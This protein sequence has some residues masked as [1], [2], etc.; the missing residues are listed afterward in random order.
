MIKEVFDSEHGKY[1]LD[2]RGYP[3][4]LV[5]NIP[6]HIKVFD[7]KYGSI[8]RDGLELHHKDGNKRNFN[9]DNLE[10]LT[11]M[12]HALRH[13]NCHTCRLSCC[14]YKNHCKRW[15]P[16]KDKINNRKIIIKE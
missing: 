10:A 1:Y 3:I 14:R 4:D 12:E 5:T 16:D 11:P 6:M 8:A 9:L 13:K 2:K 15:F 7:A